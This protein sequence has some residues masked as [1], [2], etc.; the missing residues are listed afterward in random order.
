MARTGKGKSRAPRDEIANDFDII[1][2]TIRGESTARDKFFLRFD[3][4]IKAACGSGMKGCGFDEIDEAAARV[5]GHFLDDDCANLKK[6][7]PAQGPVTWIYTLARN[8]AIDRARHLNRHAGGVSGSNIIPDPGA[9]PVDAFGN[10]VVRNDA[11]AIRDYHR[12][13]NTA[14]RSPNKNAE[15]SKD[16]QDALATLSPKLR[17]VIELHYIDGI[18]LHLIAERM[19]VSVDSIYQRHKRAKAKLAENVRRDSYN[20]SNRKRIGQLNRFD[21]D[22]PQTQR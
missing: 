3:K 6:F 10:H 11:I 18:P 22:A 15:L 17:E 13:K 2:G 20:M 8:F 5:F 21:P 14:P 19:G 1:A 7:D 4:V 16:M 12:R 9:W